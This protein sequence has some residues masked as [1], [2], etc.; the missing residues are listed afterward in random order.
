MTWQQRQD[1]ERERI[2]THDEGRAFWACLVISQ[3][4]AASDLQGWVRWAAML[5]WIAMAL[6]IRLPYWLRAWRKS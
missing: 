2:S 3:I 1:T 5:P 4:W 6:A